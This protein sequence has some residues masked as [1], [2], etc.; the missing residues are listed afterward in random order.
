MRKGTAEKRSSAVLRSV[1]VAATYEKV[2]LT[3]RYSR[4]LHLS[5][6]EQS[7]NI[8]FFNNPEIRKA[9]RFQTVPQF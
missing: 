3:P 2:G 7:P 4:A 1:R 6:F 8:G 5:I 9:A